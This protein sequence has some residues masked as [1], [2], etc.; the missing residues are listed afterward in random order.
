[1]T[2]VLEQLKQ[3]LSEET[4][5]PE[6]L[7]DLITQTEELQKRNDALEELLIMLVRTGWPWNE[8]GI[9]NAIYH[10]CRDG[11]PQAIAQARTLL[12]LEFRSKITRTEPRT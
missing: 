9:P 1:M 8:D 4:V 10:N 5:N 3:L 6:L 7:K 12:G 2:A 11:Y